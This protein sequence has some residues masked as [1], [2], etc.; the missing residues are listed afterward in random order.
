MLH[1]LA[2]PAYQHPR[3]DCALVSEH[4]ADD[5]EVDLQAAMLQDFNAELEDDSP[6]EVCSLQPL[7]LGR[8]CMGET[9]LLRALSR[10]TNAGLCT[11]RQ[12]HMQVSITLVSFHQECLQGNFGRLQQLRADIQSQDYRAK[13]QQEVV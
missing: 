4:Y 6:R 12:C 13:S 3:A 7:I 11:Q 10:F 8:S 5:L 2:G 9:C 1:L